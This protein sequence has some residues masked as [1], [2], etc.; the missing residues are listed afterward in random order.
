MNAELSGASFSKVRPI[1][2]AESPVDLPENWYAIATLKT[3]KKGQSAVRKIGG[4]EIIVFRTDTGKLGAFAAKCAHMG[5]HLKHACVVGETLQCA[6]HHRRITRGGV[7]LKGDGQPYQGL[8]Q[9][10]L[11]VREAYGSVFVYLGGAPDCNIARPNSIKADDLLMQ[12]AGDFHSDAPWYGLM[13]NGFDMEHLLSVHKRRLIEPADV[14]CPDDRTYRLSYKTQVTG[15]ALS[16]RVIKWMS[17][18]EVRASMT[19]INGTIMLIES[20]AGP[21]PT[22]FMLSLCPDDKGGTLVRGFVGMKKGKSR[23]FD[24]VRLAVAQWLF[25]EFLAKDFEIFKGLEW[26]PPRFA[27]TDGDMLS[28]RLNVYF[29][30]LEGVEKT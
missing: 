4:T 26:N 11:P 16:D 7:F 1:S 19:A 17:G 18:N 12:P 2:P 22:T 3:L 23:I 21:V 27:H 13:A 15:K 29:L 20:E 9:P 8:K 5:C 24:V 14:T 10:V 30:S 25:K 6:L 28:K